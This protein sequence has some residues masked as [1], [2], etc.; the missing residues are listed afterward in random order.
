MGEE[1]D[2]WFLLLCL[3]MAEEDD[4][5]FLLLYIILREEEE[6]EALS[7]R[8]RLHSR[9]RQLRSGTIHRRSDPFFE[10]ST[11]PAPTVFGTRY[12]FETAGS[13]VIVP[14]E[15]VCFCKAKSDDN[16]SLSTIASSMSEDSEE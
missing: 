7:F 8:Q 15:Q 14:P 12:T 6:Q 10:E 3:I 16:I 11:P 2:D 9:S 4:N 5:W 13:S 1:D